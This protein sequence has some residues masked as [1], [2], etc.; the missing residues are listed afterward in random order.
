MI[1][2][3]EVAETNKMIEEVRAQFDGN[4]EILKGN[5]LPDYAKCIDISTKASL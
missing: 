4:P 1:N 3:F 2:L 5:A